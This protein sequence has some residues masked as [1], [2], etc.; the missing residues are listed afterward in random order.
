MQGVDR[1]ESASLGPIGAE[2]VKKEQA[3]FGVVESGRGVSTENGVVS[4]VGRGSGQNRID[5]LQP[6]VLTSR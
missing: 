5:R 3:I 1:K 4:I 6:S 2:T